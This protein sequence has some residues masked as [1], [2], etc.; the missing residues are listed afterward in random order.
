MCKS[1]HIIRAFFAASATIA[2]FIPLR[3]RT[4]RHH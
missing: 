4:P 2:R 3:S 1:D